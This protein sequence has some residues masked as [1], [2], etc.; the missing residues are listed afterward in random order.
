MVIIELC[1]LPGSGKSTLVSSVVTAMMNKRIMTR[2]DLF[3]KSKALRNLKIRT[4][5]LMFKLGIYKC[6]NKI[7]KQLFEAFPSSSIHSRVRIIDLYKKI[8]SLEN[9]DGIL[10]LEEGP[11]QYLSSLAYDSE[12]VRNDLINEYFNL[13]SN[14]RYICVFC[15]CDNTVCIERIRKRDKKA[16][17]YR[18]DNEDIYEKLNIKK[19]N[20]LTIIE[21]IPKEKYT[22]HMEDDISVN[23]EKLSQLINRIAK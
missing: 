18:A 21:C 5:F 2:C 12:M 11:I 13:F 16:G 9:S 10:L 14:M 1:G 6:N 17:N 8:I 23:T 19:K 7:I 22:I 3:S 15:D 4:D 20:I